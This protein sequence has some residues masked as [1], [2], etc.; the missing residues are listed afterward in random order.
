MTGKEKTFA[1]AKPGPDV[2]AVGEVVSD[3]EYGVIAKQVS[4]S[5]GF[6]SAQ[7][8]T[9]PQLLACVRTVQQLCQSRSGA[10][11]ENAR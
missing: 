4:S 1:A 8:S 10:T 7:L 2:L 9:A 5:V 6:S 11:P 3:G